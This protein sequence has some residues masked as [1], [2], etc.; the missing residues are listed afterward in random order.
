MSNHQD[1]IIGVRINYEQKT[2]ESYNW[3]HSR[4]DADL[5]GLSEDEQAW[6]SSSDCDWHAQLGQ[7]RDGDTI[8]WADWFALCESQAAEDAL[9][10]ALEKR[11]TS[12][13]I[14]DVSPTTTEKGQ[15]KSANVL[16]RVEIPNVLG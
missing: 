11:G 8:P 15:I 14:T 10:A 3:S 4:V 1:K 7:I 12:Y 16:D 13:T 6:L 5:S 2:A 9:I